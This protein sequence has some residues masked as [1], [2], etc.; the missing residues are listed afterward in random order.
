MQNTGIFKTHSNLTMTRGTDTLK[1]YAFGSA[2][3]EMQFKS[4]T[5]GG[6]RYTFNGKETDTETDTYKYK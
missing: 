2:I 3:S 1:Y 4:D 6:Y 5:G